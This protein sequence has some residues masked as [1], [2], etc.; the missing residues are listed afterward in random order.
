MDRW[1]RRQFVQGVGVAGLGLVAGCG[2]LPGQAQGPARTPRVGYLYQGDWFPGPGG[3]FDSF[4]QGLRERGLVDGQNIAIE[5]R[6]ATDA[7]Q[8]A[9]MAAELVGSGVDIIVTVTDAGAIAAKGATNTIPIVAITLA[10]PVGAGLVASL[11][12]PGGNLTGLT[13]DA[14]PGQEAKRLEFLRTAIGGISHL[15][16]IWD[17]AG[18]AGGRTRFIEAQDAGRA[19]GIV[20]LSLPVSGPNEL[21]SAFE[22]IVRER[23]EVIHVIGSAFLLA[24]RTRIADFALQQR[25]PSIGSRRE[26]A[27]AGLLMGHGPSYPAI[28]A[29]GAYYVDR[30]LKGA[31][32]ADLPVEQPMTFDF[33]INLKTAQAL[34]LTIP[35]HVLL[36]AT[37]VIE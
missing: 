20:V 35:Q 28:Q 15:A 14:G 21:D 34:G 5:L 29:R 4:R 19:L 16:L 3:Q 36:Q 31:Q 30:I 17:P 22:A 12:R 33:V 2:R 32:P 11:A 37:E 6:S 10:D 13:V 24:N 26:W 18:S 8:L 1:S 27:D 7:D 25:L 9:T 23:V